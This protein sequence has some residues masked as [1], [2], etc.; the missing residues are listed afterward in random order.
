MSADSPWALPV[1]VDQDSP[2]VNLAP[3][4]DGSGAVVALVADEGPRAHGWAPRVAASLAREWAGDGLK[5]F[6]ADGDLDRPALHRV[7]GRENGEGVADAV[8]YGASPGRIGRPV[9][10]GGFLFASAGTVV[11]DLE[12]AWSHPRWTVLL[13]AFRESG[14]LLLLYLPAGGGD[15]LE[16]LVGKADRVIWLA[17]EAPAEDPRTGYLYIHPS[18][19]SLAGRD[20]GTLPSD[21]SPS[22]DRGLGLSPPGPALIETDDGEEEAGTD[23][24][25]D[26]S[27]ADDPEPPA[28]EEAEAGGLSFQHEVADDETAVGDFAFSDEEAADPPLVEPDEAP[29]GDFTLPTDSV[30]AGEA[31]E[32]VIGDFSFP[33]EDEEEEEGPAA[34]FEL[35]EEPAGAEDDLLDPELV[36]GDDFPSGDDSLV[37]DEELWAGTGDLQVTDEWAGE[38]PSALGGV[39]ESVDAGA[40]AEE[41]EGAP[42]A[43]SGPA[44]EG[45]LDP[46]GD[47]HPTTM[48]G[49]EGSVPPPAATAPLVAAGERES[50]EPR[51]TPVARAEPARRTPVRARP[52]ERK[53][54]WLLI[55]LL[56]VVVLALIGNHFGYVSIPGLSLGPLLEGPGMAGVGPL[57]SSPAG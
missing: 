29:A 41:E 54:P 19:G 51:P 37:P 30:G 47:G 33:D 8:V 26:L 20:E 28:R 43:S 6:L 53:T 18:E 48:E 50:R 23:D 39:G 10:E 32:S 27:F 16:G 7:L 42:V 5:V 12:E 2:S 38:G 13:D 34:A 45:T 57:P 31:E 52:V 44:E 25:G 40:A 55:V 17:D 15:G 35:P 14:S 22:Q 3:P 46:G 24:F 56:I 1:S 21:P 4:T 11:A 49:L 9:P 36:V